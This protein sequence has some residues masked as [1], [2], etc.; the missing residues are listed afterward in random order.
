M[1]K[2]WLGAIAGAAAAVALSGMAFANTPKVLHPTVVRSVTPVKTIPLRDMRNLNLP[3]VMR[4]IVGNHYFSQQQL[5]QLR[6]KLIHSGYLKAV[7]TGPHLVPLMKKPGNANAPV[8]HYKDMQTQMGQR[9]GYTAGVAFPGLGRSDQPNPDPIGCAPPDTNAAV[10][11]TYVVEIVNLCGSNGVG[12]FKVW[13][14]SGNVVQDTTSL[15]GLWSSDPSCVGNGDNQVMYDQFAHQW[16]LSQFNSSY[17]GICIAVSATSDPT[18]AY[19]L[20]DM[21]IDAGGFTDYPK[22]GLW[23]TGDPNTD[24]YFVATNDFPGGGFTNV[25]F[26]ALQRSAMLT[27]GTAEMVV[28]NGAQ[29]GLDYSDLPADVDGTNMPPLDDPGIFVNYVSP[30]LFGGG[31]PYA[32]EM[33]QMTTD[34]SNPSNATLTGPTEIDVNPFND[35]DNSCAPQ[36]SPG[37]CLPV[38]GD[39]LMFR[40]AYRSIN[41]HQ[42]LLTNH[43]VT[44]NGTSAPIGID[45]YELD[46]PSGSTNAGDWTVAQQGV[47]DPGDGNSRFMGSLAMDQSGDLGLGYTVS[48][49]SL[50]PSIA[51]AGQ[52]VGAASGQMDAPETIMITGTGVQQSTGRWG[53]YSSIMT[54]PTDDCTFWTAQEYISATGS[55]NWS[56]G[57]A[58]FKFDNCTAGPTGTVS[59]TVTDSSTGNPIQGAEVALTPNGGSGQTDG[60]GNY[61]ITTAT[62]TYDATASKFGYQTSS[63][64]SVT[65]TDGGTVTQNFQLTPAT[66]ATLSGRVYDAGHL[67][68]LYAEVKV[69]YQGSTVADVWTS[70]VNGHYSVSLPSG[71]DYTVSATPMASGFTAGSATVTLSGDT[72]QSFGLTPDSSCSAPGYHY[73]GGISENFDEGTFPP[74]GWT[75]SNDVSGSNVVWEASSAEPSPYNV[76]VTGG[77]G[78]AADADS[79]AAG[80]GVGSYDTSLISPP[81]DVSSLSSTTLKWL[82]NYVVYSGNEALDVDISTDGGNTWTN[83]EHYTSTCG[84][85]YALPGCTPSPSV[86]I[87]SY[88]PGSGTFQLRWRYY[89]LSSDYD[90]YAQVDNVLLGAQCSAIPGQLLNLVTT[91]ANTHSGLAGVT[92]TDEN[93]NSATTAA[94]PGNDHDGALLFEPAGPHQ[95]TATKNNY[96]DNVQTVSVS[97]GQGTSKVVLFRML[98][99]QLVANP[100]SLSV[101]APVGTTTNVTLHIGNSGSASLDWQ[102]SSI[103][104]PPAQPF[105]GGGAPLNDEHCS[106]RIS[107]A[108][109]LAHG[110]P[111]DCSGGDRPSSS[112]SSNDPSWTAVADYPIPVLDG[113]MAKDE[114]GTG[115]IYSVTGVS[116]GSNTASDYVYD[117]STDT[118]T[119]FA[120]FPNGGLEKPACA[121]I[122]GKLYV[123]DGWDGSGNNSAALY[124]YDPSTDSWTTGADNPNSQGGGAAG[125]AL[126]GKLYVIGGCQN[127]SSCPGDSSVEVYDPSSDSWSAAADYPAV[128]AWQSCG[129]IAGEIYCAGGIAS[130]SETPNTYV[131]DPS[132]DTWTGGLAPIPVASGGLWGSAFTATAD[133]QLLVQDGVTDNFATVT[134]EG[135]AYDV[136]SDSWSSLPNSSVT[137]YR[138]GSS[139]GFYQVGGQD[140]TFTGIQDAVVLPGFD[141]CSVGPV[142]WLT[143]N[144]ATGSLDAKTSTTSM[145][146]I[147]GTGQTAG[148]SSVVTVRLSGNTPYGS[149]TIPLTVN[150]TGSAPTRKHINK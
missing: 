38:L 98:A 5:A 141:V 50:D 18:G 121:F 116:N 4:Q 31:T 68:P 148:T 45:W 113:C 14:K 59:G 138:P 69:K 52:N 17:T 70:P 24:A 19:Y 128:I 62:G 87:G 112:P 36:P 91:D 105:H 39:R 99:G 34:W 139:C 145:L 6:N 123:A 71:N 77:S 27:G 48:G 103:D 131:Y 111:V 95:L 73:T 93:G 106:G 84:T 117:P 107:P 64:V 67:Y 78:D 9:L 16:L 60:S 49:S 104:A 42:T 85:L 101:N 134:N 43:A 150:W 88:L 63:P 83:I 75:V 37:E 51:I 13:D 35:G 12:Y 92:I 89:N 22:T 33:Y 79:N 54:D 20:Y 41:G 142:P 97:G 30:Y 66:S 74:S 21:V 15:A 8:V 124:I 125:V 28:I 3:G 7:A 96:Q 137:T 129:A 81:I 135:F 26:T 2:R 1:S 122:N 23:V 46:A 143:F 76:N 147:D 56:T 32:L 109:L 25:N 40:L 55:F 90:W 115:L 149:I 102:L 120:D 11:Q 29:G 132:T 108:S 110:K 144:S 130:G 118:W 44:T 133:G 82:E 114:T 119:A 127:G 94:I 136:A 58:A 57:L 126:N 61:S 65:I 140:G 100:T 10:G 72:T 80:P 146:A 86:D 53:D 47:Y